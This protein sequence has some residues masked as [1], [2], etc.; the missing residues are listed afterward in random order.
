MEGK[1]TLLFEDHFWVG[2]FERIDENE[3]QVA[4]II[5]G[6]EPSDA[7]LVDLILHDSLHLRYSTCRTSPTE[8]EKKSINFKRRQKLA[9]REQQQT[10]V[11]TFAQRTLQAEH[12]TQKQ[13]HQEITSSQQRFK[14]ERKFALKQKKKKEK[15]RGH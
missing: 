10:G 9:R 11:G 7:E 5:F 6:A 4:K 14:E 13:A 2:I 12:E 8:T 15:S 3:Y 1:F